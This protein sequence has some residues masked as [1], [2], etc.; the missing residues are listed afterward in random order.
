MC[1]YGISTIIKSCQL[2]FW[3]IWGPQ[4]FKIFY[5][6]KLKFKLLHFVKKNVE[7]CSTVSFTWHSDELFKHRTV[8]RPFQDEMPSFFKGH[9][10][11]KFYVYRNF[12]ISNKYNIHIVKMIM[13]IIVKMIKM[14]MMVR[15]K[16]CLPS[17]ISPYEL[18]KGQWFKYVNIHPYL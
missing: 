1:H 11:V 8:Q 15:M 2:W 3:P 17:C 6:L 5:K 18:T 16:Q 12:A 4:D 7:Q 14:T 9:Q 13:T 10:H